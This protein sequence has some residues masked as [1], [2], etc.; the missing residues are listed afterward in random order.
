M[1]EKKKKNHQ[2]IKYALIAFTIVAT[3][4]FIGIFMVFAASVKDMN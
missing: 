4:L 1:D 2:R 3:F